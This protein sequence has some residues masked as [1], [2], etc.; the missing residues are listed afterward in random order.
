MSAQPIE[1]DDVDEPI[2][3]SIGWVIDSEERAAWAVDR[4]LAARERLDRITRQTTV[5]LSGAESEVA[6]TEENFLP[7]LQHWL[8]E[9]PPR[10][11]RTVQLGTGSVSLRRVSGGVRVVNADAAVAWA[12]EH[13]PGAIARKVVTSERIVA[14]DLERFVAGQPDDAPLPP[15][16]VVEGDADRVYVNAPKK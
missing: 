13:L 15:G 5:L 8:T 11:G 3:P 7:Q 12:R 1:V 10:K 4:I 14:A 2:T 16:V 9:N 6:R